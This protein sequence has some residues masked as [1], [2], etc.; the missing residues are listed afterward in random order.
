MY[1]KMQ[2]YCVPSAIKLLMVTGGA[3]AFSRH[4]AGHLLLLTYMSVLLT[5]RVS[6]CFHEPDHG[7]VHCSLKLLNSSSK[8]KKLTS[9]NP[10][11]ASLRKGSSSHT[12]PK[13]RVNTLLNGHQAATLTRVKIVMVSANLT[14]KLR[15]IRDPLHPK[16]IFI[17]FS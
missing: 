14:H 3:V 16:L 1:I 2:F 5:G 9:H 8:Q 17:H 15:I 7:D 12:W 6:E 4:S 11:P 10:H 13:L